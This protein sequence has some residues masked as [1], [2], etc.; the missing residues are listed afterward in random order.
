MLSQG[1][2]TMMGREARVKAQVGRDTGDVTAVLAA[3]EP[4][5]RGDIRRR[6]TTAARI[7]PTSNKL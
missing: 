4:F 7:R 1:S 6:F 3:R 2:E 5:L